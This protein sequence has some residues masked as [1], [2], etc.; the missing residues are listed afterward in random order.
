MTSPFKRYVRG[1]GPAR[2]LKGLALVLALLVPLLALLSA[3]VWAFA[4]LALVLAGAIAGLPGSA[5]ERMLARRAAQKV[6]RGATEGRLHGVLDALSAATILIDARGAVVHA[7]AQA[8]SAFPA[9]RVGTPVTHAIRAPAM[10]AALESVLKGAPSARLDLVERIPLERSFDVFIRVMG[11][12]ASA[13]GAAHAV[14]FMPETTDARRLEAMRVDFV[15]NASHELRTPLASILG[16]VETLKGPARNDTAARE[17]FLGIMEEQARRMA[18]LI[19]DLLSLSRIE[20]NEHIPPSGR[21]E[22]GSSIRSVLDALSGLAR[23][24]G[25]VFETQFPAADLAVRGE[26]DELLRIFENLIENAIKYGQSGGRVQINLERVEDAAVGASACVK[27]R[28]FGPGIAP[29]HLPRLTER[30]YRA[31]VNASRGQGGTGLGLA[32]V[33]HIVTRHRGRLG[34]ESRL[35]EGSTFTIWLPLVPLLEKDKP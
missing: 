17:R 30:F 27:V 7:N 24:R 35:G 32:I 11:G 23:E 9:L 10:T 14:I 1:F 15:A 33:K 34:I 28:D 21:V 6:E 3:P 13:R 22:V 26:R 16:F 19:E 31:D 18:R 5:A 8:L 25:V 4:L 29:E 2:G 12:K 20:M